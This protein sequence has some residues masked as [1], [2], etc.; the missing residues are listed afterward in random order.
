MSRAIKNGMM[1]FKG[2]NTNRF[3]C[4]CFRIKNV[5]WV[6]VNWTYLLFRFERKR[7]YFIE[8][9]RW[10]VLIIYL[11]L[12]IVDKFN[13]IGIFFKSCS[14]NNR[15]MAS[16]DAFTSLFSTALDNS[17]ADASGRLMYS[18]RT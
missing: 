3:N 16:D 11:F 18:T 4:P 7:R 14:L 1:S 10:Y 8:K 13:Y 9:F 15:V 12:I 6:A 2:S 17:I 5:K